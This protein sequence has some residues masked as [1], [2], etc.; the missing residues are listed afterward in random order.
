MLFGLVVFNF[1]IESAIQFE[2]G[3]TGVQFLHV[4]GGGKR[5]KIRGWLELHKTLLNKQQ[6]LTLIF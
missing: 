4:R 5:M 3:S 1:E 6:G 2:I